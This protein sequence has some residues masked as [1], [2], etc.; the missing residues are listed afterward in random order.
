MLNISDRTGGT[1]SGMI[2]MNEKSPLVIPGLLLLFNL[3]IKSFSVMKVSYYLEEAWHTFFSQKYVNDV[4][5]IAGTN[6]NGPF[7]N[8]FL[9]FWMALFGNSELATRPLYIVEETNIN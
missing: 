5:Q 8:L 9:H 2:W 6:T 7:Y 4:I 1:F 3:I